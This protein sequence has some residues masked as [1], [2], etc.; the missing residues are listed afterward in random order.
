MA[1][2]G[3]FNA[4]E[5]ESALV[6]QLMLRALAK[7][8]DI[9]VR[10]DRQ[11]RRTNPEHSQPKLSDSNANSCCSVHTDNMRYERLTKKEEKGR[12]L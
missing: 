8:V 12:A 3:N 7:F 4:K 2:V 11:F 9:R 5:F 1:G 10:R 6:G